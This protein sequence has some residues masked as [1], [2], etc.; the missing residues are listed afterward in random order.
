M[1]RCIKKG[2]LL[3]KI[4]LTLIFA[5]FCAILSPSWAEGKERATLTLNIQNKSLL[6]RLENKSPKEI[7]IHDPF[8]PTGVFLPSGLLVSLRDS[9][10]TV[11]VEKSQP[12]ES[13]KAG[14]VN[15][16]LDNFQPKYRVLAPGESFEVLIPLEEIKSRMYS[17]VNERTSG[18]RFHLRVYAA[19]GFNEY[20]EANSEWT[21]R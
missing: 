16:N 3:S 8:D 18:L 10:G 21:S 14:S 2:P 7:S 4:G 15:T 1:E 12:G 17:K 5:L 20:I 9:R 11:F 19:P 13:W 6:I